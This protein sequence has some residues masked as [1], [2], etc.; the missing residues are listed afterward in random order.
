MKLITLVMI[1][2]SL[3]TGYYDHSEL[4]YKEEFKISIDFNI[5]KLSKREKR[6]KFL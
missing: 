2:T 1:I 5:N 6:R 3:I 4:T